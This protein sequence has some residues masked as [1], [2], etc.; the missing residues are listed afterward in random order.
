MRGVV[1]DAGALIGPGGS[2]LDGLRARYPRC[3][4]HLTNGDRREL[5]V[6]GPQA[7]VERVLLSELNRCAHVRVTPPAEALAPTCLPTATVGPKVA[8]VFVHAARG[9]PCHATCAA[10]PSPPSA[11]SAAH[12]SSAP[13]AAREADDRQRPLPSQGARA[14]VHASKGHTRAKSGGTRVRFSAAEEAALRCGI[15]KHGRSW[16]AILADGGFHASRTNV[17]LKDKAR[18]LRLSWREL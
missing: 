10:A 8:S 6:R 9:V 3:T 2:H 18:N 16:K 17:D 12:S 7:D 11:A 13:S 14:A 4:I 1:T 15:A 5:V